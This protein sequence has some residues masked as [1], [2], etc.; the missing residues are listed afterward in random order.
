MIR[1]YLDAVKPSRGQ[2][3]AGAMTVFPFLKIISVL[4]GDD[5]RFPH[6]RIYWARSAADRG[7]CRRDRIHG[8]GILRPSAIRNRH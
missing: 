4:Q 7:R 2:D 8:T 1:L 5:S 3:D 6:I